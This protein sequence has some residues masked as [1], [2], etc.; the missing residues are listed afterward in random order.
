MYAV[1]YWLHRGIST[2]FQARRTSR[3]RCKFAQSTDDQLHRRPTMDWVVINVVG[4]DKNTRHNCLRARRRPRS[5]IPR[6]LPWIPIS[7][8]EEPLSESEMI[9]Q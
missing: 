2:S 4:G 8:I 5:A 6:S 3:C 1:W 7:D 9:R